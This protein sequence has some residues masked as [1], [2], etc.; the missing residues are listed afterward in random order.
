[1]SRGVDDVYLGTF[2]IDGDVLAQDSDAALAFQFVVVQHQIVSLL[3][4]AEQV[5]RQ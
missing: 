4:L 5:P 1:M 2:V 3:V